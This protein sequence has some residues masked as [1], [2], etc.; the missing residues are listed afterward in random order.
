LQD[1]APPGSGHA[2]ALSAVV[3]SAPAKVLQLGAECLLT[4]VFRGGCRAPRTGARI[5]LWGYLQEE[6]GPHPRH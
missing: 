1:L 2:A 4:E 5:W 6:A 3:G